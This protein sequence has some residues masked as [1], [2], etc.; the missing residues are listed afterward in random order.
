MAPVSVVVPC[1]RS[2]ATID[3]AIESV[4]GQTLRPAEVILVDDA[5]GDGTASRL[6]A[7]A[8]RYGSP[9]I[10][11]IALQSNVGPAGARNA[12][13]A[14]AGG[15]LL[16]FLDADDA[17][18]PRKLEIQCRFMA[19]HPEFDVSGHGFSFDTFPGDV[20]G[21]P[22]WREIGLGELL[23]RNRFV[24]PSAMVKRDLP[25]RF[26]DGQRHMEDHLLW[27]QVAASGR[28]IALIDA[29][30]ASLYKPQ[31]GASGVSG[32][33]IATERAELG[34]YRLLREAGVIG[35]GKLAVLWAWSLAKFLRRL[36]LLAG[37]RLAQAMPARRS[38]A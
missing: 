27:M 8:A 20:P 34:N 19:E 4:A 31:F 37:R 28:R 7:L 18:H 23:W 3:R 35:G 33:L 5:S 30:L 38:P 26:R 10:R 9:W 11:V 16:A 36:A 32:D 15:E 29:P 1:Y 21:P 25:L 17:W 14:A 6:Q 12:G 13:W 24:M 22:T 2:A